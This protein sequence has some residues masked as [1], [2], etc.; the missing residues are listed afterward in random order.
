MIEKGETPEWFQAILTTI[1]QLNIDDKEKL[2]DIRKTFKIKPELLTEPQQQVKWYHN[3]VDRR[4]DTDHQIIE[5][6]TD[7]SLKKGRK[8]G[9]AAIRLI[10]QDGEMVEFVTNHLQEMKIAPKPNYGAP[11]DP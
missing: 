8:M 4:T 1:C 6:W 11:T 2:A 10:D 7:G 3:I 9:A 5:S